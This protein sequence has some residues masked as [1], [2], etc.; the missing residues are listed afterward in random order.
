V[1]LFYPSDFRTFSRTLPAILIALLVTLGLAMSSCQNNTRDTSQA[2]DGTGS[3]SPLTSD[4]KIV[5]VQGLTMGDR[6]CYM[7][8]ENAQGQSSEE[9]ADF[10]I[11]T[12]SQLV[13]KRVRLTRTL[14]PISAISCQGNPECKNRETVNLITAVEVVP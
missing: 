11:C 13:D 10:N 9:L 3:P 4:P 8:L 1:N 14:T 6:A 7:K 12:Q 5:V 2:T